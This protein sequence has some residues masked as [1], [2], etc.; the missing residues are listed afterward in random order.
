MPRTTRKIVLVPLVAAALSVAGCSSVVPGT[1]APTGADGT[2]PAAGSAGAP[3]STD[4]AVQWV[5]QV[6]HA[7]VPLSDTKPPDID[8]GDLQ[9]TL[10][11]LS[12]TFGTLSTTSGTALAELDKVGPSPTPNGD[13]VVEKLKT[14]LTTL[15]SVSA[16]SKASV[17]KADPKDPS[18]LNGLEDTF[19]KY[20]NLPDPTSEVQS[21][22]ELKAAAAQAENCKKIEGATGG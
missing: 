16:E 5:D 9:K 10:D 17:D 22:P 1:A 20:G 14:T 8:A 21:D 13:K 3:T 4:D 19:S 11:G 7:L 12:Q 2:A 18:S 15:Q 6:C